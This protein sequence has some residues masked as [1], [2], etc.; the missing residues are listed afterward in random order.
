MQTALR[1]TVLLLGQVRPA[2][3]N[4]C[5]VEHCARH[6]A[7]MGREERSAIR[8]QADQ[9]EALGSLAEAE[10][11]NEVPKSGRWWERWGPHLLLCSR[12]GPG[13]R[14]VPANPTTIP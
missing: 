13:T 11:R 2:G 12:L 5:E 10:C 7:G 6:G 14:V 9:R 8:G 4:P 1:E 3:Y